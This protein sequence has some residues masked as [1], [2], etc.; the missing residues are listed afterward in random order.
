M[1]KNSELPFARLQQILR[2][3][4]REAMVL[5]LLRADKRRNMTNII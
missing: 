5:H 3:H 4:A 2:K 1:A